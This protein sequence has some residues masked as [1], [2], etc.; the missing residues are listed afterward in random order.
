MQHVYLE[1]MTQPLIVSQLRA[2]QAEIEAQIVS[3]T[4]SLADARSDLIHVAAIIRIFDPRATDKP[5]TAY[6]SATKLM[7]RSEMFALCK[8]ALEASPEPLDTRQLAR[9][10]ITTEAWDTE[11]RRLWLTITHK[12]G[13]MLARFEKRGIVARVGTRDKATVWRLA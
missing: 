1:G 3:L 4:T 6:R 8:A 2:K 9:H 13:L 11:D 5:A 12:V 10:V 7:K